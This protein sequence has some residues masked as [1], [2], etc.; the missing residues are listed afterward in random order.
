MRTNGA[1]CRGGPTRRGGDRGTIGSIA[2]ILGP[3]RRRSVE[4]RAGRNRSLAAAGDSRNREG[5]ATS[6]FP[7]FPT[8]GSGKLKKWARRRNPHHYHHSPSVFFL[9]DLYASAQGFFL[10]RRHQNPLIRPKAAQRA[11]PTNP[12]PAAV[13]DNKLAQARQFVKFPPAQSCSLEAALS[14][15]ISNR[16]GRE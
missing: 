5:R 4:A 9:A 6:S 8:A 14:K 11:G 16:A 3:P 10:R 2:R 15:S 13:A 7:S 12:G 1:R